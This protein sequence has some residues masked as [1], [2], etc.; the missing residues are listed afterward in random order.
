MDENTTTVVVKETLDPTPAQVAILQRYA[1]A[2]R[3]SFNYALGLKHGAQQLW[4]YGR[5]RLIA[6]GQ[7]PAEAARSAPKVDMPSQFTI[8]KIFLAQR[9]QPL[10]GPLLPGQEPRLLYPWWKGVNAIVC[11]QAFRDADAAFNNWRSA[12][13]RKGVPARY[14]RFKRRGQCRDSFRMFAV[15]L[16]EQDLRHVKI[17]RGWRSACLHGAVAPSRRRCGQ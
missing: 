17:R 6:Q 16:V 2:S 3:C 9:D 10:P 8:Q 15:R 13:H 7:A 11:Q 5:D 4:A 12:G 1:D 14:P